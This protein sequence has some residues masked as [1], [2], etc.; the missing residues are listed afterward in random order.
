MSKSIEVPASFW[1]TSHN[2]KLTSLS[3]VWEMSERLVGFLHEH[4]AVRVST[5]AE[6]HTRSECRTFLSH[7]RRESLMT[8]PEQNSCS[9][10][11]CNIR[12]HKPTCI[13]GSYGRTLTTIRQQGTLKCR[14]HL[15]H[16]N[17]KNH[18]PYSICA[19]VKIG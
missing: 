1:L 19:G 14:P 7:T 18:K 8:R 16:F 9:F 12:L 6:Y 2:N 3:I 10:P 11:Q 15:L 17:C 13:P 4:T 5:G